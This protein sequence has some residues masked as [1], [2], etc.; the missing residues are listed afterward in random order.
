MRQTGRTSRIINF[1]VEQL[2]SVGGVIVTDHTSFE[3]EC[4]NNMRMMQEMAQQIRE[5]IER[6]SRGELTVNCDIVRLER[7]SKIYVI[8]AKMVR[9]FVNE[10]LEEFL[11]MSPT[12]LFFRKRRHGTLYTIEHESKGVVHSFKYNDIGD[13]DNDWGNIY[14]K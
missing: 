14:S 5:K 3:Y 11:S 10:A 8:H 4:E 9:S 1:A 6:D 13:R 7:G 12:K 2:W